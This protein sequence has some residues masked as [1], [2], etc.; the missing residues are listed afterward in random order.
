MKY[1]IHL[2]QYNHH[3]VLANYL[4][5]IDQNE[6]FN[7]PLIV[8]NTF[9]LDDIKGYSTNNENFYVKFEA[10]FYQPNFNFINKGQLRK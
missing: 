7:L 4:L 8:G 6:N 5:Y 1:G 9:Y 2:L 10:D 3:Q